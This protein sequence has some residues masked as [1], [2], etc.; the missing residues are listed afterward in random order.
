M[1]RETQLD[2]HEIDKL[3]A[4]EDFIDDFSFAP[5]DDKP[6]G[7]DL[8]EIEIEEDDEAPAGDQLPDPE[9]AVPT[10]GETAVGTAGET[11]ADPFPELDHDALELDFSSPEKSGRGWLKLAIAGAVV[12]WLAQALTVTFLLRQ[13][14]KI[15]GI[16]QKLAAV[17]RLGPEPEAPPAAPVAA[18]GESAAEK[19]KPEMFILS[20]YLPIYSLKGLKV[21]SA[22]LEV[23]QFP[24]IEYL[25]EKEQKKLQE[26]LRE[27]LRRAVDKQLYEEQSNVKDRLAAM[28][29]PYVQDFFRKRGV[30]LKRVR[31]KL[32]NCFLK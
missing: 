2:T 29:I 13:P 4:D 1:A 5:D 24:G 15:P 27:L 14:R 20:V 12:L 18:S 8:L 32:L 30:D 11:E 26:G 22:N 21:F 17:Q 25:G 9:S 3:L 10:A 7:G 23:V 6:E 19:I 16:V 28:I 31:I